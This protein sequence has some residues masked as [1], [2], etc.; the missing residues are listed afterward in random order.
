MDVEWGYSGDKGPENWA[1]LCDWFARGAEFP[2]QSPIHLTKGEETKIEG[3]TLSFHYQ[4]QRFTDKEFKNTIHLVPFDQLSYVEFKKERYYLT[5]IH[6][7]LPSEHIINGKQEDIEFH[8]VHM[9][10][11]KENLV[12][13]VMYQLMVQEGWLY[14][15]EN[16]ESWN[17]EKHEHWVNPDVFFPEQ[18]SHF[19]YI[20]SLTT[21]PTSGPFQW[22]VMDHVGKLNQEFLLPFDGQYARPNN[23]PIQPLNGREIYYFEE[24]EQ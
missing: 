14:N 5:D 8:F 13:G 4:K 23:R 12:V 16:G 6:F 10:S 24:F 1:S 17:L 21:P 20:G 19:H 22:F 18:K 11:K 15:Q 7:H 2:L 9:N 3:D